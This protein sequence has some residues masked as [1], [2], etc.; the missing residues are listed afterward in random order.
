MKLLPVKKLFC[1][2]SLGFGI[3]NGRKFMDWQCGFFSELS[4]QKMWIEDLKPEDH[5]DEL[6]RDGYLWVC[7]EEKESLPE[8]TKEQEEWFRKMIANS[9]TN[10]IPEHDPR[11]LFQ[12]FMSLSK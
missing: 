12:R 10:P 8:L 3:E 6:Y 1:L 2:R 4:G 7:Y 9:V 5:P 11:E